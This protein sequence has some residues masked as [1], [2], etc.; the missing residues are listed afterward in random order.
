MGFGETCKSIL[1]TIIVCVAAMFIGIGGAIIVAVPFLVIFWLFGAGL[2]LAI[3]MLLVS[4]KVAL[5][6]LLAW[7][8]SW[9]VVAVLAYLSDD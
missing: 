5:V 9:A 7:L 6:T 1:A 2:L 3:F 4:W 8:V